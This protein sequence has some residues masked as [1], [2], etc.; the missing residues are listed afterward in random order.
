MASF[1][2]VGH[3]YDGCFEHRYD[4]GSLRARLLPIKEEARYES[5]MEAHL[6]RSLILHVALNM[7]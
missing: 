3:D 5:P 6:S 2:A 7:E 4:T 1:E